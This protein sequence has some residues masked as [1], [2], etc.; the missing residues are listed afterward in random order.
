MGE[1][2]KYL[3]KTVS[4]DGIFNYR[5][6]FRVIDVW[7]REKFYDK[8]EAR[9]E[10]YV[11]PHGL[12]IETEFKP[13]KKVTDYFKIIVKIEINASGLKEVEVEMD[14]KKVKMQQGKVSIKL[15][16][17]L[18]VDYFHKWNKPLLYFLRDI[19]DKYVYWRITK[20]YIDMV[21]DDVQSL[22]EHIR[23]YLNMIQYK[24]A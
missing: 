4:Y 18:V 15:T 9:N 11:T 20:K 14:G 5:D 17:Y 6:L 13:W 19:Y 10:Q 1:K 24:V 8:W 3:V 12:T 23:T 21:L 22:Y 7:Q 16:G 2:Q